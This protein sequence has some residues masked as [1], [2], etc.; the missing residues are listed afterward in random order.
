MDWAVFYYNYSNIQVS[1]QDPATGGQ[2]ASQNAA[3]SINKGIDLDL[4]VPIVRNL[5]ATLG[6]EYLEA[7][8]ESYQN[9]AVDNIVNGELGTLIGYT[10]SVDASGKREE[11][12]PLLTSTAQLR[13][14]LPIGSGNVATTASY[15]HNSGFYFDAA[16][17]FRQKSYNLANL[18]IQYAP[19]GNRWS[20]AAWIN[21]AFNATVLGGV[22]TSPY[23][24]GAFY[25][26]PRLFGMSASVHF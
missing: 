26:D 15:Y 8:Y 6:M 23:V 2:D 11:R 17:E 21:N 4:A 19:Q 7:R 3:S 25:N 12:S 5:T 22:A 13:W 1:V 18:Y 24:V 9:A 16:N 20:V 10:K 14:L